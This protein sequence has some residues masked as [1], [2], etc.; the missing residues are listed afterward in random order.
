M[1]GD[2][3]ARLLRIKNQIDPTGVFWVTPGIGADAW[4][5]TKGTLCKASSTRGGSTTQ[6]SLVAP[7]NDNKNIKSGEGSGYRPFPAS[8]EE[9]DQRK[10]ATWP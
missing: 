9:A 5:A 10:G 4:T 2:N 7:D 3:Y 8:Q 6:G 1:W